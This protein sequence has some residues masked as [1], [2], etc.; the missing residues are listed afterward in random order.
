MLGLTATP[1]R[2]DQSDIL[3]LCDNNLVFERNIVH[4]IESKILVPFHYYGIHDEFVDYKEIPWRN[5]KFDPTALD[6]AFATQKRAKHIYEN[7]LSHKQSRT[8]AFCISKRHA[9]YMANY[10]C[11]QG[12]KAVAVYSGSEVRRNEALAE[13]SEGKI[14]VVFSVDLFNEGTD[15]PAVDTVLMTRPTESK[16][17]LF[18][19]TRTRFTRIARYPQSPGVF[20]PSLLIPHIPSLSPGW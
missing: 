12:V 14:D 8:L 6:V 17:S 1:E 16:N 3:S 18:A 11:K 9:D 7:W 15:I 20:S 10:F 4:G 5:G 19:A 2:T 13:L